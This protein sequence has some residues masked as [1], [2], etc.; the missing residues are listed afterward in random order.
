MPR[1]AVVALGGNAFTREGET[2]STEEQSH[3]AIKMAR[4]VAAIRQAGWNVVLVHGNGPQIGN[5]AIQQEEGA[6][7]VPPQPLFVLGAMTQGEMGSLISLALREVAPGLAVAALITHV[8]VSP[9][10][11][12][13]AHPTKPIGPFFTRA[14]ADALADDRG[15]TVIEDSGRGF[16]RVVASPR[17]RVVVETAAIRTLLATDT[18][19]IAGGGGGVPVVAEGAA[20]RGTEAVIDKDYVASHLA[21]ALDAEALVLVTGV[22]R[23][24]LDFG[25]PA[26]RP[27]TEIDVGEAERHQRDGHFA[28][29]SMGPKVQAATQFV[30]AGGKVA[31]ITTPDLAVSTLGAPEGGPGAPLPRAT[32]LGTRIVAIPT[33]TP[34]TT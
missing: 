31:V 29:G 7:L 14:H 5:L 30:R 23:V 32:E 18:I 13:F 28:A 25:R 22:A 20:L 34:E 17:P 15:W 19:V 16:R 10:D 12:A 1:S 33:Q 24:L 27:L 11:P 4:T 2:G 8:V 21:S 3:N 6:I 9:D 26:E